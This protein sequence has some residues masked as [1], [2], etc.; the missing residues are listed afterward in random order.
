MQHFRPA[1]AVPSATQLA[2]ACR[3]AALGIAGNRI[4]E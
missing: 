3:S 2:A 1:C 4:A